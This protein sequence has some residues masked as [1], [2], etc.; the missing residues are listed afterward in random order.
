MGK[1]LE[2]ITA[3]ALQLAPED[4]VQLADRLLSSVFPDK[5]IEDTWAAEVE[6]RINEIESGRAPLIPAAE[7]ITRARAAIK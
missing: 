6:R 3:D 2:T 1:P 7:A 4:R 5:D